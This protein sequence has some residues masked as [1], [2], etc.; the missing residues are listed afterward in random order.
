MPSSIEAEQAVL[1]ILL[2]DNAA[3]H[4]LPANL[5]P[6]QF[7]EPFHGRLFKA[8]SALVR[9]DYVAD[10]ITLGE[11][12]RADPGLKDLGGANYLA[13]LLSHSPPAYNVVDYAAQVVDSA[14][15]RAMIRLASDIAA[16]ASATFEDED[17]KLL[18][19][20]GIADRFQ[21]SL[22]QI[23][24]NGQR[25][26]LT[27]I[28]DAAAG[29]VNYV[30]DRSAPS[31]YKTGLAP[32]DLQLGP[33]Q[34]G[35]M[36]LLAGRPSMGKSAV[37]LSIAL[38]VAAPDI[39]AEINGLD[40][41]GVPGAGVIQIH[42]EMAWGDADVGGQ[43]VRRH[44]TDLGFHLYGNRFPTYKQIKD[45]AVSPDQVDMIRNVAARFAKV[46]IQGLKRTGLRVSTLRSLIRRQAA[47]W[48]RI[49]LPLGLVMIDHVGLLRAD[50]RAT[51]RYEAQTEIAIS[52][53]ELADEIR[54]PILALVQLS[55]G[56]EQRDDKRPQ[57]SD[58][59]DSGAWEENADAAIFVYRDAYYAQREAEP[60]TSQMM[61]WS[62]W[63]RR[64]RS[65]DIELILGKLRE[66]EAGNS[67]KVWG[68]L[69]WNAIRGHA[70]EDGDLL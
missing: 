39:A 36:I 17:G 45:K 14:T 28:G 65:K 31:G 32:L 19:A 52:L 1:G 3:F 34:A 37:G 13:D 18:D 44:I 16:M 56:I 6:D 46:P 12:F 10:L 33:L 55:R 59:R 20:R 70:P 68:G 38:G 53:K 64:R 58:L 26:E 27:S 48:D 62:E 43:T 24:I 21:S 51:G 50:G 67:A 40:D 5:T 47:A 30:Q 35:D 29:V 25:D 63:D 15:R 66:G 7:Y 11:Q 2:F 61:A 49:G 23:Q 41:P 8:I 4:R 60:D 54:A 9:K 57:L 69:A 42:G 22:T